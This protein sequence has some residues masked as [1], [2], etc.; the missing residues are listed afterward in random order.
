MGLKFRILPWHVVLAKTLIHLICLSWALLVY[1]QATT[2]QL[3]GDPVEAVLHFTGIGAFNLLLISLCISPLAK[4]FRQAQ[5][6][7]FRRLLGLYAFFYG[8]LHLGSFLL[9]ELQLEWRLL[10]SEIIERPYI[11]VGMAAWLI[12]LAMT[13]T[14]TK[15]LQ[16]KMGSHW[17]TLHNG[18]YLAA[19][20]VALHYIW[21]V[22][23]NILEPSLYIL[24]VAV[25]LSLRKDKLLRALRRSQRS[26]RHRREHSG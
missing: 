24:F 20:L 16:R 21:S 9:F 14:S 25:L 5:F 6:M 23:S 13:I 18:I 7:S 17:Q 10:L 26:V 3:G 8:F 12:L 2:D 4:L 11:T 22:K 15:A 1:Y 19:P